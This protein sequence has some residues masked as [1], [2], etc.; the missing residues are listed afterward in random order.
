MLNMR[1][2]LAMSNIWISFVTFFTI[3]SDSDAFSCMRD[4]CPNSSCVGAAQSLSPNEAR[5]SERPHRDH[6]LYHLH[7][8]RVLVCLQLFGQ[9]VNLRFHLPFVVGQTLLDC[10]K[11]TKGSL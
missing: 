2:F 6:L 4:I 10:V 1:F 11:F 8:I 5:G 9:F 3:A 7:P